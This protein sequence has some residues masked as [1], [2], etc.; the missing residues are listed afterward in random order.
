MKPIPFP[1]PYKFNKLN[2]KKRGPE[3]LIKLLFR[4]KSINDIRISLKQISNRDRRRIK[5]KTKN[6]SE[7][8]FWHLYRQGV[9]TGTLVKRVVN[10]IE[11]HTP[12][13]P[14]NSI[15]ID[16]SISKLSN[17]SF[18]NDAISYGLQNEAKG[19]EVLWDFFKKH[20]KQP[21]LHKSGLIIDTELAY[22]GGS[23]D[24]LL[25]CQDCCGI[26]EKIFVGEIKCPYRLKSS[27]IGG[28]STLEYLTK[29]CHLKKNHSYYYQ[30]T[31][32]CGLT[33]SNYAF[34]VVWSPH[35]HLIIPIEFDENLYIS[36]KRS[37]KKYYFD[38]YL[39][40]FFKNGKV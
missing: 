1:P 3:P 31:L 18:T 36:I 2:L 10:F 28:W 13:S 26:G 40:N 7:S 6:Q 16:K 21:K 37:V 17:R 39:Q 34:F 27:G 11:K 33:N 14:K 19:I 20:H 5:N 38:H 22:L 29:N 32:Y 35:G 9:I 24:V 30:T 25:T 15:S 4:S 23:P 8:P 12:S